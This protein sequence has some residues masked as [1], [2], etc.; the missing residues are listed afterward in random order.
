[1]GIY[2]DKSKEVTLGRFLKFQTL[3]FFFRCLPNAED[4]I[5]STVVE[6]TWTYKTI[7]NLNFCKAFEDV[8]DPFDSSSNDSFIYSHI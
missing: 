1:M 4:R 2:L 5:F 8:S 6:S 3:S 7:Q